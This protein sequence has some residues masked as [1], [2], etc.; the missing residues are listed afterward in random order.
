[1]AVAGALGLCHIRGVT[2]PLIIIVLVAWLPACGTAPG[3]R[4]AGEAVEVSFDSNPRTAVVLVDDRIACRAT[5]CTA[6]VAAGPREVTYLL[7]RHAPRTE[8]V[9]FGPESPPHVWELTPTFALL[10]VTSDPPGLPVSAGGRMLGRTPVRGVAVDAGKVSVEVA[11]PCHE[12]A[13]QVIE[14]RAGEHRELALVS[15]RRSYRVRFETALNGKPVV[16]AVFLDEAPLG[17]TPGELDVPGCARWVRLTAD[18]GETLLPVASLAGGKGVRR[19]ELTPLPAG[20]SFRVVPAGSFQMGSPPGELGRQADEIPHR[21]TLSAAFAVQDAEVSRAQWSSVMGVPLVS[22]CTDCPVTDVT[23]AEAAAFAN[24]LS[25]QAGLPACYDLTDC[26]GKPGD[27]YECG[28]PVPS[29]SIRCAG[30]RL[31]T[32]AEWEYAARAGVDGVPALATA[33]WYAANSGGRLHPIRTRTPNAWGLHDMLGNAFEW[34]QDWSAP[35]SA[36]AVTDPIGASAGATRAVRGGCFSYPTTLV[37]PAY[38]DAAAPD[39]RLPRLGFRL[40]RALR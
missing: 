19:V 21:V 22:E 13:A 18:A 30:F 12:A 25:V 23:F 11:D 39:Q 7:E 14:L 10:S 35:Y 31:P 5:P 27:A 40:V 28:S 8:I 16:A 2:R 32:E 26:Q 36:D 24:A 38:R 34:T 29:A 37:R 4:P 20:M 33:A 15:G 3:V 6:S 17:E 1:M 9:T